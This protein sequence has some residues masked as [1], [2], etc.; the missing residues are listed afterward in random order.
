[1]NEQKQKILAGAVEEFN[2]D[3]DQLDVEISDALLEAFDEQAPMPGSLPASKKDNAAVPHLRGQKSAGIGEAVSDV[4]QSGDGRLTAYAAR[5][6][7]EIDSHRDASQASQKELSI[8][9]EALARFLALQNSVRAAVEASKIDV[10]RANRLEIE[11]AAH[12]AESHRL[13]ERSAELTDELARRDT[14]IERL[15]TREKHLADAVDELTAELHA[16]KLQI[17]ETTTR[18]SAAEARHG[19]LETI[20]SGRTALSERLAGENETFRSKIEALSTQLEATSLKLSGA[21]ARIDDILAALASAEQERDAAAARAEAG[22][23]ELS[24]TKKRDD[25]LEVRLAEAEEAAK[26]A[27]A[28]TKEAAKR[29]RSEAEVLRDENRNLNARLSDSAALRIEAISEAMTLR[30]RLDEL[31]AEMVHLTGK[32]IDKVTKSAGNG[33]PPD[34]AVETKS[35]PNLKVVSSKPK[36]K[37]APADADAKPAPD[38]KA[39]AVH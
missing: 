18:L 12:L 27:A 11:N 7:A 22:I 36:Q 39:A 21:I 38:G 20:A 4:S 10:N 30:A 6:L 32:P 14:E 2:G 15:H 33:S 1:M 37:T 9:G 26:T 35:A 17:V 34:E 16:A 31:E 13:A 28:E 3:L 23:K 29:H 8:I 25:A 5:R 24:L 19:E